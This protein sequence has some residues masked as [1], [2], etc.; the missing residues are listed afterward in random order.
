[1]LNWLRN[2]LSKSPSS[3]SPDDN[4][5]ID[6]SDIRYAAGDVGL[7]TV[8]PFDSKWDDYQDWPTPDWEARRQII[9]ERDKFICQAVGCIQS[10]AHLHAHHKKPRWQGGKHKL[11]NLVALC[12][13]HHAIVHLD[14][15]K[16]EVND[17][18]CRIVSR[19]WKRKPNSNERIEVRIHIRRHKLITISELSEIRDRFHLKCRCGFEKWKGNFRQG[20]LKR[21]LI[22][23]WCPN[24]N[25][26]WHFEQGLLEETS[27]Q[28]AAIFAPT[29][30]IGQFSF[31]MNLIHGLKKLISFEGCPECLNEGRSGYLKEKRSVF[32]RFIGC[33]EW[34]SCNY[35]RPLH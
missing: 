12:P 19:H 2:F 25:W 32:G 18:R 11:E 10:G 3:V 5:I 8:V 9:L 1:M 23:T 28:L 21:A 34:P 30:N 29:Q 6:S 17:L 24:C 7:P 26:R 13:V 27:S 14:T 22:W 4:L 20:L 33:S 31:D 35:K 16:I 15:N